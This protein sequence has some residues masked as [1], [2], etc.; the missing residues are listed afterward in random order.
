VLRQRKTPVSA[1]YFDVSLLPKYWGEERLYHHTAPIT[2]NYALR[3]G[4][5]LVAEE[6]LENRWLRHRRNAERLWEGL[7]D[8]GLKCHVEPAYRLPTLTTVVVPPGVD[9]LQVRRRLLDEYS[10]EI[11]GGLGELKGKVWRIGLMGYSSRE[12]NVDLLLDA[13]KKLLQ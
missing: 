2:A 7:E 10:I 4:L 5:R 3:E 11:A 1:F 13:L 12:E 8:L 9:D 6:G